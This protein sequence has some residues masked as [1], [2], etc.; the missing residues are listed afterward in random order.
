MVM[1]D[2]L[3]DE[4]A[5][6]SAARRLDIFDT[7]N[8]RAF[9]HIV[10]LVKSALQLPIAAVGLIDED[11]QWFKSISGL[12]VCEVSRQQSFC[13]TTI[14]RREPTIVSDAIEDPRFRDH[15]AVVGE[16]YLRC[17]AGAPLIMPDGYQVGALCAA[18]YEPRA[19]SAN[20]V[21]L[22]TQLADCVVREMDLRQR[23]S[24]D[25]MTGFM[26]RELFFR[27][28]SDLL[29]S[30]ERTRTPAVL[31]ILDLDHFKSIND[32]F[33]HPVGDRVIQAVGEVCRAV[34]PHGTQLGRLG[35]EEFGIAFPETSIDD[36]LASL[37]TLRHAIAD[38]AFDDLPSLRLTGSF[39][40]CALNSDIPTMSSWCK[41]AD[42]ALYVAKQSGRN[43]VTVMQEAR[44]VTDAQRVALPFL[45]DPA[46]EGLEGLTRLL[47]ADAH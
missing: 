8:E 2:K 43:R 42:A 28:L 45:H 18:G 37:T 11:R 1:H 13:T 14:R 9:D 31:S 24:V 27:R 20:E 36:A 34:L 3:I 17:Y 40:A 5:R 33:G 6:L 22:L 12:E 26:L 23:A 30:F 15:P 39:G 4:T 32:R 44:S 10:T 47:V 25:P 38:I 19:F 46:A 16:P 21:S 35:G 29:A 7:P 41:L